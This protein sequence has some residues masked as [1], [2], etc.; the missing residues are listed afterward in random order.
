[1]PLSKSWLESKA[2]ERRVPL[3]GD[4]LRD[5]MLQEVRMAM[6]NYSL[7][8]LH[9]GR[10]RLL[11]LDLGDEQ[12]IKHY[13]QEKF[14][15]YFGAASYDAISLL[16]LASEPSIIPYLASYLARDESPYTSY[17][18]R[19]T[20]PLSWAATYITLSILKKADLMPPDTRAWAHELVRPSNDQ[21]RIRALVRTFWAENAQH[22][23]TKD[24]QAVRPP[25]NTN[26]PSL[27]PKTTPVPAIPAIARTPAKRVQSGTHT[28]GTAASTAPAL[29]VTPAPPPAPSAALWPWLLLGISTFGGWFWWRSRH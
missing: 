13:T 19:T 6:T 23:A 28:N 29:A 12:L 10:L 4:P 22:F 26:A 11:A 27:G 9:G 5:G 24:Y 20:M 1:M 15:N 21:N 7:S 8:L 18:E 16:E 14:T 25:R 17:G 2:S 3:L